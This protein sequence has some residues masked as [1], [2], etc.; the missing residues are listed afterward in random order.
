MP[1]CWPGCSRAS[2]IEGSQLSTADAGASGTMVSAAALAEPP[3]DA[4]VAGQ[5]ADDS[6][7]SLVGRVGASQAP[8]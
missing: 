8:T 6:C 1:D 5:H 3:A 2:W 7:D 4:A